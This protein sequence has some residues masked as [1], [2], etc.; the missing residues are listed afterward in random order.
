M[1]GRGAV[2]THNLLSSQV[3][4]LLLCLPLRPFGHEGPDCPLKAE[5]TSASAC[6]IPL[7]GDRRAQIGPNEVL[8]GYRTP[9]TL[10]AAGKKKISKDNEETKISRECK[11]WLRLILRTMIS[12]LY[13]VHNEAAH[14]LS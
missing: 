1:S 9:L 4:T 13:K 5:V 6:R 2:S 12:L 7:R 11:F 8:S 3:L 14:G 10:T